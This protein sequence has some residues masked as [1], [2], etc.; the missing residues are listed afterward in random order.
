M[1]DLED[2]KEP[3]IIKKDRKLYKAVSR[4]SCKQIED[5]IKKGDGKSNQCKRNK[6][7]WLAE[8]EKRA[9]FYGDEIKYFK[10][11]RPLNLLYLTKS[12][13][14]FS[15]ALKL[16]DFDDEFP[17]QMQ[18]LLRLFANGSEIYLQCAQ[19]HRF[20]SGVGITVLE[21]YHMLQSILSQLEDM[22]TSDYEL[23]F[24]KESLATMK[25][26][27]DGKTFKDS[28][29]EYTDMY[30]EFS[31]SDKKKTNQRL[32]IYQLDQILLK[33][34]CANESSENGIKNDFQGWYVPT[35]DEDNELDEEYQLSDKEDKYAKTVWTEKVNGEDVT[36][37][38]E[39]ALFD[40]LNSLQITSDQTIKC[41]EENFDEK[42]TDNP[43]S[44]LRASMKKK[45]K[46]RKSSKKKKKK[47][48][49]KKKKK[50]SSKIKKLKFKKLTKRGK[51]WVNSMNKYLK[52]KKKK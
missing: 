21:Q 24:D 4:F 18:M 7:I 37:M 34:I 45:R 19:L 39:I 36:D 47:K 30:S 35:L 1:T 28:I 8:T 43:E 41:F 5:Y 48:P 12:P 46:K 38:G 22:K 25:V 42:Q 10:V 15:S 3:K 16:S 26:T 20:L 17:G 33:A 6:M 44:S 40:C 23:V 52:K 14:V 31:D 29:Q 9:L 51:Q 11:N 50:K 27:P 49:S 13:Y 2:L 32:S